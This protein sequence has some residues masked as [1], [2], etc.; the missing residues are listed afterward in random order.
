MLGLPYNLSGM[1]V[2]RGFIMNSL[3]S[4]LEDYLEIIC[5]YT[6]SSKKVRAIDISRKLNVSRASTTE[7]LKKLADKKLINYGRYDAISLTESGKEIAEMIISKHFV[8]QSFFE[9]PAK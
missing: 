9:K 2:E 3:S 5:N 4:S 6:N 1:I 7:A 8:L